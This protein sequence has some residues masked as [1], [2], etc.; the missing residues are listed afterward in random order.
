MKTQEDR[1]RDGQT[2]TWTTYRLIDG[3]EVVAWVDRDRN[4]D[5]EADVRKVYQRQGEA[6][7]EYDDLA[8]L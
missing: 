3:E 8:P 5:G 7:G 1:N 6:P 2:D 4:G